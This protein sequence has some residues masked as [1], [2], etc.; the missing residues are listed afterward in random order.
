MSKMIFKAWLLAA[1]LGLAGVAA[2]D[3]FGA[4]AVQTDVAV[5]T[6]AAAKALPD[7]SKNPLAWSGFPT[8]CNLAATVRSRA[9]LPS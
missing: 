5:Q 9:T 3:T 6:V 2:A 8:A 7:D 4:A 1:G